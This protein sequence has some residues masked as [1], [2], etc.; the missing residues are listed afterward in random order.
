MPQIQ[1]SLISTSKTSWINVCANYNKTLGHPEML[2]P[3]MLLLG[4]EKNILKFKNGRMVAFHCDRIYI[5]TNSMAYG[6]RRFN[7][8]FTRALQ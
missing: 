4:E 6:T 5:L 3:Y 2:I 1:I 7:A 8:A